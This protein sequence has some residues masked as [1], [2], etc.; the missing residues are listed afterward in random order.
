MEKID[1][2]ADIKVFGIEVKTFPTGVDQA[3]QEL[4]KS[5]GDQA[6]ERNYYGISGMNNNG[7]MI[8]KAVA[9]EKF[10]GEAGKYN[11]QESEIE[12][13]EYFFTTLKDWRSNTNCIKD[14]FNDM[15]KDDRVDKTKPGVEWYKNDKEMLCM[16]KALH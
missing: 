13:G 14:I 12:K 8:Y 6:G 5:T 15:I 7:K 1:L 10:K 4:I 2:K 11:Y 3:F 16:V 9:E